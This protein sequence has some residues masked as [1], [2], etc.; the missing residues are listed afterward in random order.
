M[1]ANIQMPILTARSGIFGLFDYLDVKRH[2]YCHLATIAI[3]VKTEPS[4]RTA[5]SSDAE[6]V[7]RLKFLVD[8]TAL[9]IIRKCAYVEIAPG[10]RIG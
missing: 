1:S 7:T 10:M 2:S 6:L 5:V 3:L 8:T 9:G 4:E